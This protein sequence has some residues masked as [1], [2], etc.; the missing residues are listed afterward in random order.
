MQTKEY[1]SPA[2]G[3]NCR[4]TRGERI[5][6]GDGYER[7]NEKFAQFEPAAVGDYGRYQTGDPE[8]I[9]LLD[10]RINDGSKMVLTT[11]QFIDKVTPDTVKVQDLR[12]QVEQLEN[13]LKQQMEQPAQQRKSA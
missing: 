11:E 13:R 3:Y 6:V 9:A 5:K 2:G 4:L 7:I 10:A 1:Y 12:V 8:E